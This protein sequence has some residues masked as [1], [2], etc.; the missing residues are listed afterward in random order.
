MENG[1]RGINT[2][3]SCERGDISRLCTDIVDNRR[4][5]P[6]NIEM[7]SFLINIS[8]HATDSLILDSSVSSVDYN[9]HWIRKTHIQEMK[10]QKGAN[11][12]SQS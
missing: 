12:S 1:L 11:T 5:K 8:T 7:C 3:C 10:I 4:L 2:L 9:K 6:R